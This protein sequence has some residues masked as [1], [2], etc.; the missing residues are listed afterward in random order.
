VSDLTARQAAVLRLLADGL[1]GPQIAA[2]LNISTAYLRDINTGLYQRYGAANAAQA[3]HQ[4]WRHGHLAHD[5]AD[6]QAVAL[7][8]QAQAMGYRL[9]L[10]PLEDS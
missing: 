4:A 2:E 10:I 6:A 5:P 3:V 7:V 8:R 9:A 1:T